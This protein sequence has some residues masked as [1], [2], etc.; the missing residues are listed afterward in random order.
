MLAATVPQNFVV[1]ND[2]SLTVT[3]WVDL[4][5][6]VA[7]SKNKIKQRMATVCNPVR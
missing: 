5:H 1:M 6:G 3:S 2:S 7:V 4:Q